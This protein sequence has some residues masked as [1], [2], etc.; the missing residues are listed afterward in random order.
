MTGDPPQGLEQGRPDSAF[1]EQLVEVAKVPSGIAVRW[2]SEQGRSYRVLRSAS[3]L[4]APSEYQVLQ[5][6][7]SAAPPV[8]QFIDTT[9]GAAALSF[10]RIEIEN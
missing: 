6:A 3:L 1:R 2:T 5:S 9:A 7:I 4:A 10:Y 8:N